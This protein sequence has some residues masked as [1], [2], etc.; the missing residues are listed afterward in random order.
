VEIGRT[1]R[2][3]APNEGRKKRANHRKS[4]HGKHESEKFV[5]NFVKNR[6]GEGQFVSSSGNSKVS[7]LWENSNS[8]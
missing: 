6:V 2:E 4:D 8:V 5:T 1:E 7:H 3:K